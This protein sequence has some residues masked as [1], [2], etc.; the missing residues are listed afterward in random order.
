MTDKLAN[1]PKEK[2]SILTRLYL[3]AL[4]GC[5][6][7]TFCHPLDVVR[8]QMQTTAPSLNVKN[9]ENAGPFRTMHQILRRS[10]ARGLWAGLSAAYLRQFSYG[11]VRMG[12]FSF[13]VDSAKQHRQNKFGVKTNTEISLQTTVFLGFISGIVG[14]VSLLS[15]V[16]EF[17][18]CFSFYD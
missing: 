4:S 15:V 10:G 12:L 18:T 2:V 1:T 13:L 14:S 3:S 7:S 8:V 6:A 16:S 9:K 11:A 17:P 5:I